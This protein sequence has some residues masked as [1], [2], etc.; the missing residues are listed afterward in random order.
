MLGT[1]S[2]PPP[3]LPKLVAEQHDPIPSTDK[4]TQRMIVVL[5]NATLETYKS[6]GGRPGP[7]GKEE[8]YSLLN[9][10]EHIGVMRKMNR[11]ISDAR[12][13][14]THQVGRML[15]IFEN[16]L[17]SAVS[18][19]PPRLSYQQGRQAADLYPHRQRRSHRSQPNRP[20]P[21][22]LQAIRRSHGS[23]A[24]QAFH[25]LGLLTREASQG[26]RKPHHRPPSSQLPKSYL[27]FQREACQSQRLHQ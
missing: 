9:S 22:Y 26:H 18:P 12:P 27:E 16:M 14:I 6:S 11:D 20:H 3:D 1:Q 21:S 7:G 8:K 4:D 2:L 19:Y 25:P 10:D 13:D 23:T 17:T 24:P 15:S 5:S